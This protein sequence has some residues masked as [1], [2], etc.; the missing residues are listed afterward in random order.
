MTKAEGIPGIQSIPSK[1]ILIVEDELIVAKVLQ[2]TLHSLGY[3]PVRIAAIGSQA[4]EMIQEAVPDLILMDINLGKGEPNGIDAAKRILSCFSIPIIYLTGNDDPAMVEQTTETQTYGYL[5]KSINTRDLQIAIE[6]AF[7]RHEKDLQL[8]SAYLENEQY[9]ARITAEMESLNRALAE[10]DRRY[11]GIFEGTPDGIIVHDADGI[12]LEANAEMAK[13]L[14]VP[15]N[16]LTGRSLAEFVLPD[17]ESARCTQTLTLQ[18]GQ[19]QVF[20]TTSISESG[21]MTPAEVHEHAIPWKDGQAI[22]SI[23]RDITMR[24]QAEE[25]LN[26]K[27]FALESSIDGIAFADLSGNLTYVNPE[28][29]SIWGYESP[30]ELLGR[31]VLSFWMTPADMQQ[32]INTIRVKGTWFGERS[33]QRKDGTSLQVQS[34]VNMIRDASGTPVGIMGSFMD[35]TAYKQAEEAL[36]ETNAYLHNLLDHTNAP[37][38]TWDREFRTTGFNHAFE[39]LTGRM[40]DQVLGRDVDILFPK[41]TREQTMA[42]LHQAMAGE[43]W[44]TVEIPVL[45]RDGDIRI[46]LW[47]SATLYAADGTSVIAAIAQGQD[48]TDRVAALE[49]LSKSEERYRNIVEDQTEFICRFSPDGTLTF[50]NAAYSRYFG[51]DPEDCI[52]KKHFVVLYPDDAQR[53]KAHLAALTPENPVAQ[54]SH[55]ILMP[56]GEVRWNCWSDRAIYD[57]DGNLVEYQSVGSDITLQKRVETELQESYENLEKKVAA[58]TAELTIVNQLL[59]DEI[60][61]RI[62]AEKKQTIASSEKDLLLREIHHRV[63]NN[64]QLVS[65]LLDMT[66]MR[67][68]DPELSSTITDVM[69]KIQTM[70]QIHTRLYES[71]RFDR[72]NMKQQIQ[73]QL[74]ALSAIYSKNNREVANELQCSGIYLPVDQAI[75]CALILNEILSNSYKHAFRGRTQGT[76]RISVWKM[77]GRLRFNISDDGI[78]IPKGFDIN[79]ANRLGLKLVRTLVQQQLKGS[80]TFIGDKGTEVIVEFP[81]KTLE[82]DHGEDTDR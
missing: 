31:S 13:R 79:L 10:S 64:L 43:R 60:K 61:E 78:G 36:R 65:G 16:A 66:K 63:K 48:I 1:S 56:S 27:N 80:L 39:R 44:E 19:S 12:I 69:L 18:N 76:V 41:D 77:E 21:K 50:I 37:I 70:A 49:A 29:L 25:E 58:R 33:A 20:E 82:R 68:Q 47:N 57:Q 42:Y 24:K 53:M 81:T 46:V 6:I 62:A 59:R 32:I 71:R 15:Q 28:F 34:S 73:D 2:K 26:L 22:I 4:I 5:R 8:K 52:G 51:L 7:V 38:I 35:V 75:P 14:E 23:S 67:T 55:R 11:R 30:Q 3:R 40:A 54:I 72:I 17:N 45:G 9:L 74:A